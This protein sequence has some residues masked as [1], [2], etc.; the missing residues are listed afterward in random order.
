MPRETQIILNDRFPHSKTVINDN[1]E[2]DDTPI[3]S[4]A[5]FR[6]IQV[7]SSPRGRSNEFIT[8]KTDKQLMDEFGIADPK[9]DGQP[10]FNALELVK[11]IGVECDVMRVTP[12]DAYK[13]NAII[14]LKIKPTKYIPPNDLT[15]SPAVPGSMDV[16]IVVERLE[17]LKDFDQLEEI[18]SAANDNMEEVDGAG[19]ITVPLQAVLCAGDGKYGNAYRFRII[20]DVDSDNENP[21]VNYFFEVSE[22][23]TEGLKARDMVSATL[24]EESVYA[25]S[26]IYLPE[27]LRDKEVPR[28]FSFVNDE[29]V[30]LVHEL[31]LDTIGPDATISRERFDFLYGINPLTNQPIDGYNIVQ[32]AETAVFDAPDGTPLRGGSD[33]SLDTGDLSSDTLKARQ[34]IIDELYVS[35]FRGD[36]DDRI[37]SKRRL[38]YHQLFDANYSEDVKDTI[39]ALTVQRGD[40]YA[41]LD[42]GFQ[43]SK[44]S[45]VDYAVNHYETG[46]MLTG[47][48]LWHYTVRNP[49]NKRRVKFTGTHFLA[50]KLPTHIITN[51]M[52][53]P[54]AGS[55]NALITGHVRGAKNVHPVFDDVPKDVPLLNDMF[56]HRGNYVEALDEVNYFRGT[57]A[58][59]KVGTTIYHYS[60]L[61]EQSNIYQMLAIKRDLEN[62]AITSRYK[63][64]DQESRNRYKEDADIILEKYRTAGILVL[65]VKYAMNPGYESIRS[66]IHCY[67][68][69]V[70][71][72][73]GKRQIIEIDINPRT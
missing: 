35:A 39:R 64:T 30:D 71:N 56:D 34:E 72:G 14:T 41:H 63:F 16:R 46:D 55:E 67:V 7:I 5:E 61:N 51:G 47:I 9:V 68:E 27:V 49:F 73:I 37:L 25:N 26:T 70:F 10:Y 12:A 58:T 29:A 65:E 53:I 23:T 3:P 17:A 60:D 59:G 4:T 48:E 22:V 36:L 40:V 57:Q 18:F 43:P 31:Y 62:F 50:S 33:G 15:N 66:I 42:A 24:F 32:D 28:L 44:L 45:A 8:M 38:P 54:F 6:A 21:Y 20:K 52:H 13:A 1:T 19:Y 2:Y 69:I 11:Q